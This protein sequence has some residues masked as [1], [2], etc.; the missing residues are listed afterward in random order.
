MQIG[1]AEAFVYMGEEEF[2]DLKT[3]RASCFVAIYLAR[4]VWM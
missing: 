4:S 3:A 1:G 2:T